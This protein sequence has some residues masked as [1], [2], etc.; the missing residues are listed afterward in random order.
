ML[1]ARDGK[2]VRL[3][4]ALGWASTWAFGAALGVALG[5]YLTLTSGSGAP[6][7]SAIDPTTD[8]VILPVVA[9]GIVLV[10]HLGGQLIFGAVRGGRV[11][12]PKG[13]RDQRTEQSAE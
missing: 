12:R 3:S 8:L 11:S 5:G 9:F 1:L 10:I 4:A 2:P 6:G 13:E 7:Q